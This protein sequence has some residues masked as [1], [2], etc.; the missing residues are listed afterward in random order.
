METVDLKPAALHLGDLVRRVGDDKLATVTPCGGIRVADLLDH[1]DGLARAFAAAA[2]K[3]VG[4]LT[5]TPPA[6]D[7]SRL[8][9]SWRAEIPPRLE[10]LGVAWARPAAWDGMTQVGGINLPG[11]VAGW[12]ALNEVVL[13]GWDLARATG[14]PYDQDPVTLQACLDALLGMYPA[15]HLERRAGI[16][17][18]PVDVPDGA[19]LLDRTVA[20]SGRDPAWSVAT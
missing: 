13:H 7:G 16:F 4:E 18:A 5:S 3:D 2:A 11:A 10:A 8:P 9:A 15:D 6:P 17:E 1:I 19:S 14:L 20:F 12:I